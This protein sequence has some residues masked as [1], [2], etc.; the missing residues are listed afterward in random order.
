MFSA[1]LATVSTISP[2]LKPPARAREVCVGE[3]TTLDDDAAGELED[4][5]GPR[6]GCTRA[7]RIVEFGLFQSEFP[8]DGGM[9]A[10]AVRAQVALS[11]RQRELL[12]N[13][14]IE[15]SAGE[16]RT[17]AHESFKRCWRSR[18]NAK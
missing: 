15:G 3:F 10:Q 9:R 17:Q 4:G 14:F 2:S 16:G 1:T 7:N 13:F 8:G 12:A 6:I 18:K 11:N 5:I